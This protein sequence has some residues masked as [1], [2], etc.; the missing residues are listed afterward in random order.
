MEY[1]MLLAGLAGLFLGGEA[2][3][4]GSVGIAQRL[5]MPPLLIGLTVV[6]FGTSTPELLVSVDAALRGVSDIAL[7]NVVGSNIANILLI[8]GVSALVWPIRVSGDT[9]KRDTAVMMAA[10]IALVP[11][12]AFGMMGRVAGGILFASLV[13]YLVFAYRQSRNAPN[14]LLADE[15]DLPVPAR[16]LWL[17]LIWVIG[18]LVALMFGARFMV[19]GAVTIA[20]TFGVSEAF[21]GLTVV[22]VGT[23]LP[24][25]ATSL[26]AAFRK[27]SE[28]AIGNI[29]GSNIF[30]I[31]GILGLTAIIAPIPVASR[32]LTFDLPIMI[33]VSL[34]LTLLLRR[35]TIGRGIGIVMLVA[36]AGYVLAA[37]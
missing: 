32:F 31:L 27:Q 10:A 29:V 37:Q 21:I 1:L 23:S 8:V 24:E 13:A 14:A 15:G 18:G 35:Q 26:I 33:G 12:F 7:G 3:V 22:A 11:I 5:A 17:S 20:R 28:I 16:G 19:D 34:V 9:L 2:L 30:N 6:G 25:L 36:Y 4:R